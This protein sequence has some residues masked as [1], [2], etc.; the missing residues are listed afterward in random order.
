M[1]SLMNKLATIENSPTLE[2]LVS[3]VR[4]ELHRLWEPDQ[5]LVATDDIGGAYTIQLALTYIQDNYRQEI[6]LQEVANYAHMSKNYFSEQFKKRTGFNFIDFVIRLRIHYAK[7]LL[8]TTSM[9][10]VDIGEQSGFNSPK[11]FLKLFK[12]MTHATPGEYREQLLK[13][14]DNDDNILEEHQ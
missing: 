11:H 1:Q 3:Y 14:H 10:V 12:R 5:L 2:S 4:K 13:E 9:R 8:E 6:S 7:H